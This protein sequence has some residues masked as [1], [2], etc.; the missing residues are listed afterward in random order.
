[1]PEEDVALLE[2]NRSERMLSIVKD[3]RENDS[4]GED[5][6][7]GGYLVRIQLVFRGN[8]ALT[9]SDNFEVG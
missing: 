3:V 2:V 9:T 7:N 6:R 8:P 1:M 5:I 4:K